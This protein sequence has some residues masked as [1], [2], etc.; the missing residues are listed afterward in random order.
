MHP[1]RLWLVLGVVAAFA[2]EAGG[3]LQMDRCGRRGAL[4]GSV[5][6]RRGKD[7]DRHE[8]ESKFKRERAHAG[9]ARA[10]PDDGG[11]VELHTIRCHFTVAGSDV[12]QTNDVV[13]VSLGLQ[14][15]L[16][17]GQTITWHLSGKELSDVAPNATQFVLPRMGRGTY[18]IAATITDP[19]TGESQSSNS[20]TF[21]VRQPSELSPQHRNP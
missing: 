16:K 17:P 9:H 13:A 6:S 11:R 20:V 18:A 8:L 4:F 15:S 2:A 5:D 10:C 3:R 1:R 19:V 21:F 7:C 12:F 14:P